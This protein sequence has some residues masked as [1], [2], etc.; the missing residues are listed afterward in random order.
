MPSLTPFT[1]VAL[2]LLA[3]LQA[4]AGCR[5]EPPKPPTAEPLSPTTAP[6]LK[7]AGKL[8]LM[9]YMPWYELPG[10]SGN[11]KWGTHWAGHDRQH[12][13][14]KVGPDG[15]PDIWSHYHP[16]IGLYDSTDPHVLECHL[17]QMKLAGI[18]GV[19]VDWY[20]ISKT[21]DYPG[22]HRSTLAMFDAAKRFDMQFAACFEDRTVEGMIKTGAL[23][24]EQTQAH[25]VETFQWMHANWLVAPNYVRIDGRP[26]VLNFGPIFVKDRAAWQAALDSVPSPR[27]ALF[28]LH[29]L[30]RGIGA[31]GAFTWVHK[32]EFNQN[33]DKPDV[34]RRRLV[35]TFNYPSKDPSQVIVS[36]YPGFRDVYASPHPVLDHRNGDTLR[37]TLGVAMAGA[38]KVVQLV[39]WNDYGEGTMIEPTH[40]FGYTF[41][42]IVQE[43]RRAELGA[44]RFTFRAE[45]LRLP[46]RLYALRKAGKVPAAELDHVAALLNSG[47]ASAA[48]A[49]LARLGD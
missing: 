43:A 2:C 6:A 31:D 4:I 20:G 18:D 13:P 48:R 47:D 39:T 5:G 19:I 41:L 12:D 27:P 45:D 9:H 26:L 1:L 30:W 32:D 24:P 42:E 33:P 16:L 37:A 46:A 35:E 10:Q 29:H 44:D 17:L 14:S 23:K 11:G 3:I 34:I 22:I 40:E 25:L 36:A 8:L 21:Y 49:L 15:L 7:K 28:A 38:W